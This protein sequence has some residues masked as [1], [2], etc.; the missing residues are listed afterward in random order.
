MPQLQQQ[1]QRP[2]WLQNSFNP[3]NGNIMS[4]QNAAKL[5]MSLS[6]NHSTPVTLNAGDTAFTFSVAQPPSSYAVDPMITTQQEIMTQQPE[7][8]Q[9]RQ[10]KSRNSRRRRYEDSEVESDADSDYD[11]IER[12]STRG[13]I[14]ARRRYVDIPPP[15]GYGYRRRGIMPP[16]QN[17]TIP[18]RIVPRRSL[19]EEYEDSYT[20][21]RRRISIGGVGDSGGGL[22]GDYGNHYRSALE[23]NGI[24]LLGVPGPGQTS[25]GRWV[26]TGKVMKK[27]IE[28]QTGWNPPPQQSPS[29]SSPQQQKPI[30]MPAPSN[31][32]QPISDRETAGSDDWT[33][34]NM[35]SPSLESIDQQQRQQQREESDSRYDSTDQE[36]AEASAASTAVNVKFRFN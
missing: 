26:S 16:P 13:D 11:Y 27:R 10:N 33:P 4:D 19:N 3:N 36:I 1:Q 24:S 20:A 14:L 15:P 34:Y 29:T 30:M 28:P 35:T 2:T 6:A 23:G 25:N 31:I 17:W 18:P 5:Q 9:P 7:T 12:P 22:T 21:P 32:P 8:T